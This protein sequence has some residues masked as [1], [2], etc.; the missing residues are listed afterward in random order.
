MTK[1]VCNNC[2]E[3]GTTHWEIEP[4]GIEF[5][6]CTLCGWDYYPRRAWEISNVLEASDLPSSRLVPKKR[7]GAR[8][9]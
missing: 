5:L 8:R 9:F 3:V 4:R 2:K 7:Q 6:T 1:R